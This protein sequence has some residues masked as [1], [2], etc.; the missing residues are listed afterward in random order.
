MWIYMT[1]RSQ[2]IQTMSI[3]CKLNASGAT[4]KAKERW[5]LAH[6]RYGHF[7]RDC[8]DAFHFK[9][10]FSLPAENQLNGCQSF[11]SARRAECSSPNP[12]IVFL[13]FHSSAVGNMRKYGARAC[14]P[15]MCTIYISTRGFILNWLVCSGNG[16]NRSRSN[17]ANLCSN[18]PLWELNVTFLMLPLQRWNI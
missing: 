11:H 9:S 17:G 5:N 8:R 14:N 1:M 4:W 6:E 13:R 18:R 12:A 2:L 15:R 3:V 10:V 7:E 16:V